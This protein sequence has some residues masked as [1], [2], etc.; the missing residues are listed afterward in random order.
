MYPELVKA[1]EENDKAVMDAY[2]FDL[3]MTESDIVVELCKM[4]EQITNR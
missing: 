1:H 3:N 4:Y 2:G